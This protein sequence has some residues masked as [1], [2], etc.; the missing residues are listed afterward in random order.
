M[1]TDAKHTK[2]SFTDEVNETIM[3]VANVEMACKIKLNG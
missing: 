2:D 1:G 3:P